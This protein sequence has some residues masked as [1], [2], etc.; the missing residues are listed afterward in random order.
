MFIFIESGRLGNQIFQ[1][2]YL[3]N[4]AKEEYIILIGF[5]DYKNLFHTKK[6][7]LFINNNS[8][9]CKYCKKNRI[10]I[11]S[12]FKKLRIFKFGEELNN[13]GIIFQSGFINRIKYIAQSFFQCE[14][15]FTNNIFNFK[16]N[17]L[18]KANLFFRNF[19]NKQNIYFVHIRRGDYL[20]Y[21]NTES[22]AFIPLSWFELNMKKLKNINSEIL[23]LIFSDDINYIKNNLLNQQD[24]IFIEN[25]DAL[26]DF[27]IMS[28][29]NGGILSASSYSWSASYLIYCKNKYAKFI[30]PKFWIGHRT[31]KWHPEFIQST[32]LEYEEVI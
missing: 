28:N 24:C 21:P 8:Y 17:Y 31:K 29:C 19:E 27:T 20:T 22:P 23:F 32:F 7:I 30:A 1:L 4:F 3:I 5:D 2:N 16:D 10:K 18:N 14:R 6:N 9:L 11:D 13:F 25:K 12:I 26:L 15:Y